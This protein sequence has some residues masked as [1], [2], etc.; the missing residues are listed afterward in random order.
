MVAPLLVTF[1]G[2]SAGA[3]RVERVDAVRGDELAVVE[4][5]A[6]AEGENPDLP[7]DP[8]WVLRGVTSNER[9]VTS[10]EHNALAARQPR[11]GRAEATRAA[12]I[13]IRK[14]SAWW[15]L[16]QDER[17]DIL[18]ER[19]HHIGTGLEY[20][21]AVARRLHHCRDLGEPFDFLT[22]FE[23]APNDAAQFDDLV[24]RLRD[25]EE[26]SFVDREVDIRLTCTAN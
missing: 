5:I 25:T 24:T 3:W 9:Y 26:W 14:S 16:A 11:L 7:V 17:R 22:W 1:A 15:E 20:L 23:Y 12:L 21:P 13:P 18:E 8:R 19:S 2:G 10:T 4:R 6:V